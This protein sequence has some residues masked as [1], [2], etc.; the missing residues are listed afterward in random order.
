MPGVWYVNTAGANS[1]PVGL[2]QARDLIAGGAI[3]AATPVW[4]EG[5]SDWA[6][7]GEVAALRGLFPGAATPGGAKAPGLAAAAMSAA[8]IPAEGSNLISELGVWSFFWRGLVNALGSGLIIPAPW[9]GPLIWRYLGET[10]KLPDG[11]PFG[12]AG[13][14][15]DIWWV[16]VLQGLLLWLGEVRY[17]QIVALPVSVALG[18]FVIK[19][20]CEKLVPPAGIA[21]LAFKGGFWANFGWVALYIVAFVTIIGWAWVLAAYYR[22]LA[23]NIDGGLAF[24]FRG[25][26]LSILWRMWVTI[27]ACCFLIPIPWV[28]AWMARWLISQFHVAVRGA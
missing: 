27:F 7:A 28:A 25:A 10:T 18:Y 15:G 13:K 21:P 3:S 1:G 26:G 6:P 5:M 12:F 17:V 9:T 22:W 4:I 20:F 24:E 16:F 19:W 11:R 14:T 2:D 8:T 23:R